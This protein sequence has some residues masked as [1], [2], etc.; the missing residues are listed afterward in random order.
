MIIY[1]LNTIIGIISLKSPVL[2]YSSL[3]W[4]VRMAGRFGGLALQERKRNIARKPDLKR[5]FWWFWRY[6]CKSKPNP[7][8]SRFGYVRL[9]KMPAP[10]KFRK[11][12]RKGWR[13]FEWF[14]Q[15][16]LP[17]PCLEK[18]PFIYR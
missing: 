14:F 15:K 11:A 18:S 16:L 12:R 1:T 9:G 5:K 3:F 13:I 6:N 17:E 2:F 8:F 10:P 4:G 7:N